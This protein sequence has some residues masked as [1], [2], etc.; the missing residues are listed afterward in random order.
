M[1]PNGAGTSH[2]FL[3]G[4]MAPGDYYVAVA[5]T[6]T[7]TY[8]YSAGYFH[9][10]DAPIVAITK[11]SEEGSD[12]DFITVKTGNPWDMDAAGDVDYTLKLVNPRFTV[13]DYEDMAGRSFAGNT[14]FQAESEDAVPGNVGDPTVY[15][16]HYQHRGATYKIDPTV[17]HRLTFKMGLAGPHS[18]N[19]G[20]VARVMWKRSDENYENV[21][22]DIVVRHMDGVWIMNKFSCD[23]ASLPLE[24]GAGSPSHSGWT[25]LIDTFRI[26]PHEFLTSRSFFFDNVRIA[27]DWTADASF[28][29]QWAAQDADGGA[30]VALYYDTD[31]SGYNGTLIAS[32]L[33]ASAG[34]HVWNTS[35]L[36][37]GTYYVYAVITD[38]TNENQAYSSG[39]VIIRHAAPVESPTIGLSRTTVWLGATQNGTATESDKI[40]VTNTGQGALS[41]QAVTAQNWISVSPSSGGDGTQVAIGAA[42]TDLPP[43]SYQGQVTIQD[44]NATNN[45]QIITVVLSIYAAGADA[46]PFGSFDTPEDQ[47][48]VASSIA[49]TGW[50]LDDIQVTVVKIK[51]EP[52]ASHRIRPG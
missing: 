47:A 49:V 38:G 1:W 14:V 8:S 29:I 48:N 27:A 31:A 43:G 17:Y 23:L 51:R 5:P 10:N 20:S 36:P 2:T 44:P 18:T 3:V 26:D 46:A 42:R 34:S 50:A 40:L 21:S 6:G 13:L 15:F 32:G 12:Q 9:V 25:G 45:P 7:Q 37:E 28:T 4:G 33:A 11:P 19:D 52:V 35:G 22:Q 41:W 39:P 30:T 16:L 24:D